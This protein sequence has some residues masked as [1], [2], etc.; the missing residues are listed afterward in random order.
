MR[1]GLV[2]LGQCY[3]PLLDTRQKSRYKVGRQ[4]PPWT[5]NIK[6]WQMFQEV[7]P[8][9]L[10][11]DINDK[12]DAEE[13]PREISKTWNDFRLA[14]FLRSPT[15]AKPTASRMM[16]STMIG[17]LQG[18]KERINKSFRRGL[19]RLRLLG[20]NS[21]AVGDAEGDDAGGTMPSGAVDSLHIHELA[22]E[23][24]FEAEGNPKVQIVV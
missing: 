11:Y 10:D 23:P 22:G 18:L 16:M 2:Q 19:A 17:E 1:F 12:G 13:V 14:V 21:D 8:E 6:T 4:A 24:I 20:G 3:R 9:S 5:D 7:Y 15:A